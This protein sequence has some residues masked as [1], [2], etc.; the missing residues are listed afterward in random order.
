MGRP[1][2]AAPAATPSDMEGSGPRART[3]GRGRRPLSPTPPLTPVTAPRLA[4]VGGGSVALILAAGA[5]GALNDYRANLLIT[6]VVMG[7]AALSLNVV[8][9]Y[10]GQLSLGHFALV[11][12]GAF[13]SAKVTGPTELRLPFMAALVIVPVVGALLGAVLG[14]PA[15]R[16]RGLYLAVVTIGFHFAMDQSLFQSSL[17]TRGSAGTPVPRP[18]IGGYEMA[19]NV[20]YL[21]LAVVLA[22]VVW[23]V[24]TNLTGSRLGRA[25]QA[26]RAD[27]DVAAS[28]GI[29]VG[30]AKV[31][32]FAISGAYAGLAGVILG[33]QLRALT[34]QVFPFEKSLLLVIIVV[35]GGLGSRVGIAVAAGFFGVFPLVL[36]SVLAD[37]ARWELIVGSALMLITIA[38][39]PDGLAAGFRHAT[40]RVRRPTAGR[41]AAATPPVI[42][43][44]P[45]PPAP[46][47]GGDPA[48]PVLEVRSVTV[49]FGGLT[50]VDGVSLTVPRGRIVGLIGPNGAGKTTLFNAVCG[51]VPTAGGDVVLDGVP[52]GGLPAHRR[53]ERGIGRTF[54]SIGLLGHLGVLGNLLVAQHQLARYGRGWALTGLGPAVRTER[55]LRRRALEAL[56]VLGL[57]EV[58]DLPVRSLSGG[59]Q[60]IVE[61][62]AALMVAPRLLML[63]EPS[64]GMAPAVVEQLA[65]R[66]GDL[67]RSGGHTVLL[68]EHNIPL[69]A[70]TCDEVYVMDAGR[71]I[72]H[73]TPGD[74]LAD[75]RVVEAY[76][77]GAA[78]TS[79]GLR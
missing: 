38:R 4:A 66:L 16:I 42:P 69:V 68:I 22:L 52:I 65:G 59:Q 55:E 27:E 75:P 33:A 78:P 32:A 39:N 51:L 44:L 28:W 63:D 64:A 29:D 5:V 31:A 71:V 17:L 12:F 35:L 43:R 47:G 9:G 61:M 19:S 46:D 72:A 13:L 14:L 30:R 62:A 56:E 24:D 36:D 74:V 58:A 25:F 37:A 70:D 8:L 18:W 34:F 48:T 60:R 3:D 10:T 11:G 1:V 73:G 15:L 7:V 20:V 57:T 77:G 45:T 67:R 53:V 54:Q 41:A 76:L 26:V 23:W 2:P 21:A 50:A 6:A 40:E 79:G 49:R